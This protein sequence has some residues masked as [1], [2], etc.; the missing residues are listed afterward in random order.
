MLCWR[1]EDQD[2]AIRLAR[3]RTVTCLGAE[4]TGL[5]IDY[6]CTVQSSTVTAI[7]DL[8]HDYQQRH[9]VRPKRRQSQIAR[10][11]SVVEREE[12]SRIH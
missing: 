10:G 2:D 6:G 3:R 5:E 9:D 12:E 4:E 1:H 11:W 8:Q 7:E